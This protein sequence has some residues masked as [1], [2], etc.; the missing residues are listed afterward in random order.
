MKITYD[1]QTDSIY[2]YCLPKKYQGKGMAKN[3]VPLLD[4]PNVI[5]DFTENRKLLGIEIL[6]A[7]KIIDLEYLKKVEFKQY[8]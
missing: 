6:D 7:S 8:D 5:L 1:K 3:T 2:V 4:Y